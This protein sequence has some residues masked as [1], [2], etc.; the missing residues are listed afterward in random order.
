[1]RESGFAGVPAYLWIGLLAPAQTP[2]AV[3]EKLN[4]AMNEGLK[5]SEVQASIAKLGLE[6]R[7]VTPQQFAA[8]LADETRLWEAAV[9]ESGV[10]LD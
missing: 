2:A 4:G 9:K 7:S 1:M 6:T 5:A 3:I 8:A 10:Q